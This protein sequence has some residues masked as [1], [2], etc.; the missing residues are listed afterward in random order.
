MEATR[1]PKRFWKCLHRR[2]NG[3]KAAFSICTD[4]AR[5]EK[6]FLRF[7]PPVQRLK[8]SFFYL[9]RWCKGQIVVFSICTG[10]ARGEKWFLRFAPPVQAFPKAL[11]LL[12]RTIKDILQRLGSPFFRLTHVVYEITH[13]L[14]AIACKMRLNSHR[15]S[16]MRRK[17]R[18][19]CR[20][21]VEMRF[22]GL[23]PYVCP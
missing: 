1:W 7:A 5:G 4:G 18:F 22:S 14:L 12:L 8:S 15:Q 19:A 20:R 17:T 9:H 2:C 3:S 23:I 6:W 16:E 21:Q 10:G 13:F 11:W